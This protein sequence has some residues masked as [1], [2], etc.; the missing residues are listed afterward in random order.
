MA[1]TVQQAATLRWLSCGHVDDGKS[2]LMGAL[3]HAMGAVPEDVVRH[4]ELTGLNGGDSAHKVID[5]AALLDGLDDEHAQGITIDVAWRYARYDHRYWILADTPGHQQY[6]RNMAVAAS[7]S[8][9]AILVLDARHGPR[10]QTR[11]HAAILDFFAVPRRVV[12]INKMD[13]IDYSK[14]R[15]DALAAEVRQLLSAG[16]RGTD[17]EFD[18]TIIPA[19]AL[20]GEMVAERTPKLSWYQGPTVLEA[21]QE[22]SSRDT[23]TRHPTLFVQSVVRAGDSRAYLGSV[24]GGTLKVGE[25]LA[26]AGRESE[27]KARICEIWRS[28]ERVDAVSTGDAAAVVL[29]TELDLSRGASLV[30]A[31]TELIAGEFLLGRIL[32]LDPAVE[33]QKEWRGILKIH[34]QQS[35]VIVSVRGTDGI[36]SIAEIESGSPIICLPAIE[37]NR[38]NEF[39][40]I[41][42]E[43]TKTAGVG[44][45]SGGGADN[46]VG[47]AI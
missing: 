34:H 39:L 9:G 33:Q 22:L 46:D 2:T 26:V 16:S 47:F 21:V 27:L 1:K 38:A 3:W 25:N 42:A 32:W 45:I 18:V 41:D 19:C 35:Q 31:G 8:D 12:V 28:G 10:E 13:L 36:V 17:Q 30:G 23:E 29:D 40:L 44:F 7:Y 37:P 15:F 43:S 11:R 5:F 20:R 14:E 24:W 6:T 4:L